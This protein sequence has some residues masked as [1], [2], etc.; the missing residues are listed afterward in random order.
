MDSKKRRN[1]IKRFVTGLLAAA[2]CF[3]VCMTLIPQINGEAEAE[4]V[5]DTVTVKVGYWGMKETEYVEKDTF[6]WTEL[7]DSLGLYEQAYSFFQGK[8]DGSYKTVVVSAK[9]FYLEDILALAGVNMSDMKNI[10]FYTNDYGA[11][12]FTSFTPYQ[13]LQEPRYYYD[14]MASFIVNEYNDLGILT[15]YSIDP[16]V[17]NNKERVNT[18][19]AL[20]SNWATYEAGTENTSPS[21]TNLGTGSRFRLLFG[22]NAPDEKR[23]NQSAKY[24][25]TIA[26]TIDGAPTIKTDGLKMGQIK[27]SDKVGKHTTTFNVAADEAM[28]SL[29]MDNIVWESSDKKVLQINSVDMDKSTKYAD[30]VQVTIKYEVFVEGGDATI[31]GTMGGAMEGVELSGS[32]IRTSADAPDDTQNEKK[33]KNNS[34]GSSSDSKIGKLSLDGN[35]TK[36]A[37]SGGASRPQQAPNDTASRSD[38]LTAMDLEDVMTTD[39]KASQIKPTDDSRKYAPFIAGGMGGLLILGGATAAASFKSQTTGLWIFRKRG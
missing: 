1:S 7:R 30:A 17:E 18:M 25:H 10:S 15:G 16:E 9:G 26:V 36:T 6:H 37:S 12:V 38:M 3:A 14:N 21:F 5:T 20:E 8:E 13:L 35:G 24:V 2:V 23:T 31:T 27:L 34:G 22:Q 11:G 33:K 19:L 29:I 32:E 28:L 4:T 39:T